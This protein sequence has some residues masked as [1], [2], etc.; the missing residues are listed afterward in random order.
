[1]PPWRKVLKPVP[2]GSEA[3]LP[4]MASVEEQARLVGKVKEIPDSPR[5][6]EAE[7]LFPLD[8]KRDWTRKAKGLDDEKN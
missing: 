8:S 6:T 7:R 2:E 5:L 4:H 1:M 3:K